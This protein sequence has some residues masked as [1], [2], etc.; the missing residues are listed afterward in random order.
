MLTVIQKNFL[1]QKS[2]ATTMLIVL[3]AN[4]VI[5]GILL[6]H[7]T[8]Q[9]IPVT[10]IK[11]IAQDAAKYVKEAAQWVW[12]KA[13]AAY[14]AAASWISAGVDLWDKQNS[15]PRCRCVFLIVVLRRRFPF[16][17]DLEQA[18]EN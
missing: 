18:S 2:F 9:A 1:N 17:A 7:K 8:A 10:D 3:I 15:T 14:H 5:G 13:Q 6:P 12:Q 16:S 11:K 4:L